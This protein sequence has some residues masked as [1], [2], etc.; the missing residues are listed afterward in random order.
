MNELFSGHRAHLSELGLL[1][2]LPVTC[3]LYKQFRAYKFVAVII[4]TLKQHAFSQHASVYKSK[5]PY[6][7]YCRK[8]DLTEIR[9]EPSTHT[10]SSFVLLPLE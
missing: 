7:T 6:Q 3:L 5:H 4:R 9:L 2:I 8:N 1:H 10:L